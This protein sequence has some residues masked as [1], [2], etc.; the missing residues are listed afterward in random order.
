MTKT[1]IA[2]Y[3]CQMILRFSRPDSYLDAQLPLFTKLCLT[4][5]VNFGNP[6]AI[7]FNSGRSNGLTRVNRFWAVLN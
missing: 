1:H 5:F 2:R 7:G 6:I 4:G 3:V